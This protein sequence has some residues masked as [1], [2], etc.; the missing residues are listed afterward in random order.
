MCGRVL[1]R[2]SI[3]EI[4]MKALETLK[5]QD[6]LW[7]I[8][9]LQGPSEAWTTVDGKRVLMLC[10]NNYLGL[11]NHPKLKKAA[12]EAIEKYGVGSGA[13]RVIAGTMDLHLE[14]EKKVAEFK[15]ADSS[16]TFQSGFAANA[17][18]IPVLAEEGDLIISDELNHGSI[19]DGARLSKADRKIYKHRDMDSL[20]QILEE[21]GDYRR[22]WIIT[23]GVFSMDGDV[24]PLPK[25]VKL[26][27]EYGAMVYVDD[28]HGEGVLGENGRGTT[29]HFGVEGNVEVEMGTF[30]KAFGVV[31][32]Y[33]A[34]SKPLRD[35]LENR[36]RPYLL[37]GSHPPAVIASCIAAIEEVQRNPDLLKK[38]WR[39]TD[40][41]K[42]GLKQIGY[43]IGESITPITPVMIGEN[44][45]TQELADKLF[46]MGVFVIPIV[47]P[48][49]PKGKARIRTI[50]TAMHTEE[51]L[52]FA[53]NA[54]EKVGKRLGIV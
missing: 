29:S 54:F 3:D 16:I 18:S 50:V 41:W 36:V 26:A 22:V 48:M 53:L 8:R 17:G 47:Y 31:G 49:V 38:L 20:N 9:V 6:L 39:N 11:C 1:H 4:A 40:Y 10:S 2:E 23:D 51:D 44:K 21:S 35:Y 12:I 15:H 28:A 52:N 13:V 43:D 37:S 42:K 25:I 24:A 33:I 7:R 5:E 14:L 45:P 32:G 27:K 46:D 34:C 19:I 30:S